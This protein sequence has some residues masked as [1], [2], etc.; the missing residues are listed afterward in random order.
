MSVKVNGRFFVERM[1]FQMVSQSTELQLRLPTLIK[2]SL[3]FSLPSANPP[4]LTDTTY[5]LGSLLNTGLLL[6]PAN[7]KP[8]SIVALGTSRS[9]SIVSV[10]GS[11]RS[12]PNAES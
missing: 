5:R 2:Q 1:K 3:I 6:P 12:V 9:T 11:E 10:S 7:V 4:R 8:K